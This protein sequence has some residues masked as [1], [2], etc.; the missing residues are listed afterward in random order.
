MKKQYVEIAQ[1]ILFP[2]LLAG[3]LLLSLVVFAEI[4]LNTV[5]KLMSDIIDNHAERTVLALGALDDINLATIKEKNVLLE[6]GD[7]Q[8]A[9]NIQEYSDLMR[10]G[11]EKLGRLKAITDPEDMPKIVILT[12]LAQR[13]KNL[14][15]GIIFPL[16]KLGRMD[17]AHALSF[18]PDEGGGRAIRQTLRAGLEKVVETNKTE[19]RNN[20]R[21]AEITSSRTKDS[22][23][24]VAVAGLAIALVWVSVV[25]M[26]RPLMK[27]DEGVLA[28]KKIVP[29]INDSAPDDKVAVIT[30]ALEMFKD[31]AAEAKRLAEEEEQDCERLLN[32]IKKDDYS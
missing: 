25:Q 31:N 20:R 4:G 24:L 15:E 1:R 9:K 7:A 23:I 26:T 21:K 2:T 13:Y 16:V 22:L 3:I 8:V 12:D 14:A 29:D 11:L 17:Q 19:M 32:S 18:N 6:K 28:S 5:G 10:T 30:H 27:S